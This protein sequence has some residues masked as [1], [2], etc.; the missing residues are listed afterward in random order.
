MFYV[1][2]DVGLFGSPFIVSHNHLLKTNK[3]VLLNK[4]FCQNTLVCTDL[5]DTLAVR[6][7]HIIPG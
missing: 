6:D 7:L 2:Q 3:Q 1:V 5:L 4:Y